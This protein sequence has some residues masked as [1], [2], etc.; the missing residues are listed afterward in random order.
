MLQLSENQGTPEKNSLC[1]FQVLI[2][3]FSRMFLEDLRLGV[4]ELPKNIDD[5]IFRIKTALAEGGDV[6]ERMLDFLRDQRFTFIESL[7]YRLNQNGFGKELKP[8][9][10]LDRV[11]Q[12]IAIRAITLILEQPRPPRHSELRM[13]IHERI[14]HAALKRLVRS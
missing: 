14:M 11:R 1:E 8:H 6:L 5:I 13:Y 9:D 7:N 3:I 2:E 10:L 4:I 12:K